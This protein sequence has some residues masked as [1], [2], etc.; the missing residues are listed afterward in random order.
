[1]KYQAGN[2]VLFKGKVWTIAK[3]DS[4]SLFAYK[5]SHNQMWVRE[6][7]LIDIS[8]IEEARKWLSTKG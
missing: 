4:T 5:I 8:N 7:D 1:M 2:K 3:V 6:E